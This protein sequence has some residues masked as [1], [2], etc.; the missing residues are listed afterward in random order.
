MCRL[1]YAR[2]NSSKSEDSIVVR[3]YLEPFAEVA[4]LSEE[5]QGH[6]WG[7]ALWRDDGC[8]LSHSITPIWEDDLT[9]FGKT[10][11]LV[12]HAR[13][14]FRDE[15]ICVENN[16]P[17]SADGAIFAFNGEL[18][19]VRIA[20]EGRIGAEKIFNLIRKQNQGSWEQALNSALR[21]I[22]SRTRRVRALNLVLATPDAAYIYS[23]FDE[24]PNYFTLH[25]HSAGRA[26]ANQ[27]TDAEDSEPYRIN[28]NA[29]PVTLLC[30]MPFALFAQQPES[31]R[32]AWEAVPTDK[33]MRI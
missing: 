12:I 25:M 2:S 23:C 29:G 30:S 6:G 10:R 14:A 21:I 31:Q 1:L 8:E 5:Y 27:T 28:E 9:R 26:V 16:M 7:I 20:E 19:G 11:A 13:S 32:G 17:F 33:V 3:D 15:G 22:R 4:R 18:Q 24:R